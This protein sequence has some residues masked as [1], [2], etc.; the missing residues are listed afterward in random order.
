MVNILKAAKTKYSLLDEFDSICCGRPMM[1]AGMTD[2]AKAL[3]SKN[4]AI[5]E[6]AKAKIL[7]TSCPICFKVFK[8]EYGLDI[9][10]LHHTQYINRLVSENKI[11]LKRTHQKVV[12]HDPCE[13]GRGSGVYDAPRA[14]LNNIAV[15]Q[16]FTHQKEE[17]LCC[18]GSIANSIL[19]PKEKRLIAL[20]TIEKITDSETEAL[21]TSCP[22]CKKTFAQAHQNI[23]IKD[24]AEFVDQN[25]DLTVHKSIEK[26]RKVHSEEPVF[27]SK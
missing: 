6:S 11:A 22:L 2:Q 18:G 21:I 27:A 8:E 23:E 15:L 3:I 13:L 9:E 7:V 25:L 5:I 4:K 14:V 20:S 1:L 12:Y 19:N 16:E 17:S 24:I 10:V 26:T